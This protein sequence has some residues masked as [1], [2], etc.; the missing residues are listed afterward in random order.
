MLIPFRTTSQDVMQRVSSADATARLLASATVDDDQPLFYTRSAAKLIAVERELDIPSQSGSLSPPMSPAVS[1]RDLTPKS[2]P[3]SKAAARG[4]DATKENRAVLQEVQSEPVMRQKPPITPSEPLLPESFVKRLVAAQRLVSTYQRSKVVM[5]AHGFYR[6]I[7]SRVKI[8][9]ASEAMVKEYNRMLW[10]GPC[11]F[12]RWRRETQVMGRLCSLKAGTWVPRTNPTHMRLEETIGHWR[13]WV[14]MDLKG[15]KIVSLLRG[16]ARNE[17]LHEAWEPFLALANAYWRN[18]VQLRRATTLMIHLSQGRCFRHWRWA[19]PLLRAAEDRGMFA[20]MWLHDGLAKAAFQHWRGHHLE[21]VE[22][23]RATQVALVRWISQGLLACVLHW[24]GVTQHIMGQM[25]GMRRSLLHMLQG[26]LETV[27]NRWRSQ[28]QETSKIHTCSRIAVQR[29]KEL[30][31]G[32]ALRNWQGQ[33]VCFMQGWVAMRKSVLAVLSGTASHGFRTW[34]RIAVTQRMDIAAGRRATFFMLRRGMSSALQLW[35]ASRTKQKLDRMLTIGG[36]H[37]LGGRLQGSC[38]LRWRHETREARWRRGQVTKLSARFFYSS[39]YRMLML[40]RHH[41]ASA[42]QLHTVGVKV[43]ISIGRHGERQSLLHWVEIFREERARIRSSRK[44]CYRWRRRSILGAMETMRQYAAKARGE[45]RGL[46]QALIWM[47]QHHV[48]QLRSFIVEWLE[49]VRAMRDGTGRAM[50]ALLR[51]QCS[52]QAVAF[53]VWYGKKAAVD[54]IKE[55]L[56]SGAVKWVHLGFARGFQTWSSYAKDARQCQAQ[57]QRCVMAMRCLKLAQ[58]VRE[59]H[60][61]SKRLSAR[62]SH[63][64]RIMLKCVDVQRAKAVAHWR[65]V[66]SMA[67]NA[68]GVARRAGVCLLGEVRSRSLYQ[69]RVQAEAMVSQMANMRRAVARQA[70]VGVITA[71]DMWRAYS[72]DRLDAWE[73][74][75]DAI[76]LWNES[77]FLAAWRWWIEWSEQKEHR[78]EQ[79]DTALSSADSAKMRCVLE[80]WRSLC[81]R[82]RG[83]WRR[84]RDAGTR[85]WR[86]KMRSCFVV[87]R[88]EALRRNIEEDLLCRGLAAWIYR[89][90]LAGLRHWRGV[91]QSAAMGRGSEV[92]SQARWLFVDIATCWKRWHA[93]AQGLAMRRRCMRRAL[94]GSIMR[95]LDTGYKQWRSVAQGCVTRRLAQQ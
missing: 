38:F 69:W 65:K 22:S 33:N 32:R 51:L 86:R 18:K 7:E 35:R 89:G 3:H 81:H 15:E 28:T 71:W 39:V 16:R 78:T 13:R 14:A 46:K 43:V 80:W 76:G 50:R 55:T 25:V 21:L 53:R 92:T 56:Q 34:R 47:Q 60:S 61:T 11:Y 37:H 9:A 36:I 70:Y 29:L 54:A 73:A 41:A 58:A 95:N 87:L 91:A 68:V 59:W 49:L 44:M 26:A 75:E 24:R 72:D 1:P 85:L 67:A 8:H 82:N 84:M 4:H 5:Q 93:A 83:R 77:A 63:Q 74:R 6:W 94:V 52:R 12:R 20:I 48:N 19:L 42:R 17:A 10:K 40:W 31:C 88:R 27:F 90:L 64:R 2:T 30:L 66:A 79:R 57:A 45:T 62:I 23:E